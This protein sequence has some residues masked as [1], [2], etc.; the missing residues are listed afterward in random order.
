MP[1]KSSHFLFFSPAIAPCFSNTVHMLSYRYISTDY[2]NAPGI[3]LKDKLL[4]SVTVQ[5]ISNK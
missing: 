2:V 5:E 4:I 1:S 3:A